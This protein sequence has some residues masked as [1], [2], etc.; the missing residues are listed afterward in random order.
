MVVL[1]HSF[2][3]SSECIYDYRLI[4]FF[5]ERIYQSGPFGGGTSKAINPL[6]QTC[7]M[8]S[9]VLRIY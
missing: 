2:I 5:G 9:P 1:H 8:P 6:R 3:H 7:V 4:I